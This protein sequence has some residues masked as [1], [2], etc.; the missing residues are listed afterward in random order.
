MP[1]VTYT[2]NLEPLIQAVVVY[3]GNKV[4]ERL[5]IFSFA[6]LKDDIFSVALI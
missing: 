4:I 3:N 1:T 6:T 2:D 5:T